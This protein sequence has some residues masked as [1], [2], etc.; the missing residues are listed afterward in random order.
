MASTESV[1][2]SDPRRCWRLRRIKF[3]YR[4]DDLLVIR[5]DPAITGES[6]GLSS[7]LEI[8]GV[9][10]RLEG[11]SLF[12]GIS[13]F[14]ARPCPVYVARSPVGNLLTRTRVGKQDIE[15]LDWA[16][17]YPSE[18]EARAHLTYTEAR[19]LGKRI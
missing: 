4:L 6:Y 5:V 13:S 12:P 10:T 7:A 19:A 2:L 1:I 17:L 14:P 8:V 16:E 9:A 11:D 3:T 18:P 15:L